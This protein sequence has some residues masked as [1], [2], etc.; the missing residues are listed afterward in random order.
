ML[1]PAPVLVPDQFTPDID[2]V[3][4]IMHNA[5]RDNCNSRQQKHTFY[6]EARHKFGMDTRIFVRFVSCFKR[7]KGELEMNRW[8]FTWVQTSTKVALFLSV[9]RP[10]S[11]QY[12]MSTLYSWHT[13]LHHRKVSC[14]NSSSTIN[15]KSHIPQSCNNT[16]SMGTEVQRVNYAN[17]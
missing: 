16:L 5:A 7:G 13:G 3:S 17:Q 12:A 8:K 11:P 10:S 2:L 9:T 15:I 4:I 1:Q 14:Q 6:T